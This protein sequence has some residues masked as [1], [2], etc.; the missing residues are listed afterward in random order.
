MGAPLSRLWCEGVG[1]HGRGHWRQMCPHLC[2]PVFC[3]NLN[4][5]PLGNEPRH[6][7]A[8]AYK[9]GDCGHQRNTPIT[10][11]IRAPLLLALQTRADLRPLF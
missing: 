3:S 5:L 2:L 6:Q 8:I 4:F 9:G 10:S 1:G 11:L 7:E